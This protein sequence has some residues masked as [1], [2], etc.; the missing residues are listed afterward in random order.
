MKI[1]RIDLYYVEIPFIYPF[2]TNGINVDSHSCLIVK[3]YSDGL[4]GY[5]ECPT[6]NQPFYNYETITTAHHIL[7]DFLIPLLLHKNINSPQEINQIL[8]PVRGHQ[9]AKSALDCALWDLFA[10]EKNLPLSRYI[11]GVREKVTVGVSVSLQSNMEALINRVNAYVEEGYQRI[12]LK[13]SPDNAFSCLSA[14]RESYPDLMLMGD[15]N[16]VFTLDDIELF[17]QLDNLNLLMIEQPLAYDDL[18]EHSQLQS[19][20]KTPLCLDESINSI[21]DTLNAIALKSCQII[22]LKQS[23]VGGITNTINIHNICKKAGIKLWCGGMLE[24]GIGRATNLH[25]ASLAQ[26]QFPADISATNRYF[27]EDIIAQNITLNPQDSTINVPQKLG[28]GVDIDQ[29]NLD[30]FTIFKESY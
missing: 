2:K 7:K 25:I 6:F 19:Q 3:I 13:I 28:I 5:G 15:A 4:I 1:E 18:L 21:N 29:H 16:S 20:I 24:S 14:I 12:K 22:N 30:F 23:R 8:S 27:K 17:K 11:N 10:K 9:M 26:F